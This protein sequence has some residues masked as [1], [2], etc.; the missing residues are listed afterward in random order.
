MIQI[1][2]DVSKSQSLISFSPFVSGKNFLD[3]KI[4]VLLK[5][6]I[7]FVNTKH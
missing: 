6:D 3:P 7:D 2:F 1:H 4:F 5:K